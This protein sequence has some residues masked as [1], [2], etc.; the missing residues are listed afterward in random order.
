VSHDRPEPARVAGTWPGHGTARPRW[1]GSMTRWLWPGGRLRAGEADT[2]RLR[3]VARDPGQRIGEHLR[4]HEVLTEARRV[5]A[6]SVPADAVCLCLL[7]DGGVSPDFA[8]DLPAGTPDM[9]RGILAHH[10]HLLIQDVQG[11]AGDVLPAGLGK[12]LRRA[13]VVALLLVPFE[14]DCEMAGFVLAVRKRAGRPWTPAEVEV[15]EWLATDLGRGLHHARLYEA[16]N[17]LISELKTADQAKSDFLA[18]LS[19]E[20]RTPLTSIA[21]YIEIL[22]DLDAGP[23][24][25]AQARMLETVDR[26]TARLRHVIED[27]LTLSRIESGAF[28]TAMMPVDLAD[29]ITAAV[30]ALRPAAARKEVSLALSYP[31]PDSNLLVAGDSGQL[32]RVLVTLL[33]NAVKFTPEHGEVHVSAR[34]EGPELVVEIRDTGLGIPACDQADLFTRFFRGSNAVARSIPGAGLGLAIV[35]TVVANH[36]GEIDLQSQEDVGTVATVR[37]PLLAAPADPPL[38]AQS[39]VN[40][41]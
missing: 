11:P 3:A 13:G 27:V 19:H 26:S 36:G 8:R 2:A 14:V 21:G 9:V 30:A 18:T 33:S 31:G 23:L 32:D 28:R 17:R 1:L 24:T 35:R 38:I 41:T 39:I 12:P 34:A 16:Q 37:L 7:E 22:R 4:E 29:V 6:E 40:M 5:L 20:L 10:A 15:M 25:A